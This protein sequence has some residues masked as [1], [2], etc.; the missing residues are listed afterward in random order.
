MVGRLCAQ[1]LDLQTN[2]STDDNQAIAK[3]EAITGYMLHPG[4]AHQS[5]SSDKDIEISCPI[6]ELKH[7]HDTIGANF[8]HGTH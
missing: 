6:D 1:V 2:E 8:T 7:T 5:M 3:G 4:M